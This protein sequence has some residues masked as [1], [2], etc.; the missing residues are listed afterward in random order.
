M[1]TNEDGLFP[2]LESILKA[3]TEPLDCVTIFDMPEIRKHAASVNRVSDYLGGL[4]RKGKV[5]RHQAPKA[6]NSRARWMYSWKGPRGP[7]LHAAL[8][9]PEHNAHTEGKTYTPRILADRPSV[10]I[11]EEGSTITI[12]LPNLLISIRTKP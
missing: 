6:D 5:L 8:G 11:T 12:E 9:I 4:W 2:A 1:R 3:A 7:Q 10:L